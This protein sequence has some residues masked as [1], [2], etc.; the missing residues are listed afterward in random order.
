[1]PRRLLEVGAGIAVGAVGLWGILWVDL[2]VSIHAEHP[3]P[4][5][6]DGDPC[7]GVPD[8]YGEVVEGGALAAGS[9]LVDGALIACAFA[10]LHHGTTSRWPRIR[11]LAAGPLIYV[12]VVIVVIATAQVAQL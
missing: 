6:P 9:A 5:A 11:W 2:V 3:D 7:C 4:E 10:L 12:L 1:M 8:T